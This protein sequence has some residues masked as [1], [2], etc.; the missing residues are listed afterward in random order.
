MK[1]EDIKTWVVLP[2]HK[3]TPKNHHYGDSRYENERI[4]AEQWE[5]FAAQHVYHCSPS[6][7]AGEYPAADVELVWQWYSNSAHEWMPVPVRDI[8]IYKH[9][10]AL[11]LHYSNKRLST[12]Q[13]LQLKQPYK[14]K[15]IKA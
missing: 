9:F 5:Q 14:L 10:G 3:A 7:V 8:E 4:L 15:N 1:Y 11:S 2:E 13:Y 12:R 6:L